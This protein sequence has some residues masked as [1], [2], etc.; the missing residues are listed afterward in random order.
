MS[1]N[2]P[3]VKT[4]MML[5]ADGSAFHLQAFPDEIAPLILLV[6]DPARVR[7]IAKH[8]DTIEVTRFNREFLL[9]TGWLGQTR[10]TVISTGIGMDN[11]DI[12]M[13]ELDM[14]VNIDLKNDC[15]KSE[16]KSLNI[17]RIGTCGA[18]QADIPIESMLISASAFSFE[19]LLYYYDYH[20]DQQDLDL[21]H[22]LQQHFVDFPVAADLYVGH[23]APELVKLFSHL[24]HT[25]ITFTASGFYGPQGRF[26]RAKPPK[27]GKNLIAITN[28][29]KYKGQRLVN[30]E[31]ESAAIFALGNILGH[32]SCTINTVLANRI[33]NELSLHPH[34]AI[35]NTIRQVLTIIENNNIF[36]TYPETR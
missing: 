26:L 10:I 17:I 36:K 28:Q 30:F 7:A 9:E 3:I 19:G 23:A 15:V 14:L 12:V 21:C 13:N 5:N 27:D 31:M 2:E 35:E 20:Y 4:M 1:Q 25:G 16:I 29:F 8:F 11:V 34:E 18:L 6:G 24:G 32:R 33:T 22:A